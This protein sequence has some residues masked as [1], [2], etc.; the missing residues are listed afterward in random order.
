M[1]RKQKR[2]WVNRI[3]N[4]VTGA[5]INKQWGQCA[6]APFASTALSKH[7]PKEQDA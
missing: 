3:Q 4:E 7:R 5:K 1:N 2:N 6:T